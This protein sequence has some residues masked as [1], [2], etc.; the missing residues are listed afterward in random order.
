MRKN[1]AIIDKI[2]NLYANSFQENSTATYVV[3]PTKKSSVIP[4]SFE[5]GSSILTIT[6]SD[7]KIKA[8]NLYEYI[9]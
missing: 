2:G 5:E 1:R 4:K 8:N 3:L 9:V 7:K 6:K